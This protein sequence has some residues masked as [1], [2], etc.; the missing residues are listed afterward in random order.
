MFWSFATVDV[1]P[2]LWCNYVLH[3]HTSGTTGMISSTLTHESEY[4]YAYKYK[5]TTILRS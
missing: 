4:A 5:H 3:A 1:L 2:G